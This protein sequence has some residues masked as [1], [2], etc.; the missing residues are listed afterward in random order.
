[1]VIED[2]VTGA[3]DGFG[4]ALGIPSETDTR[5]NVVVVAG[6]AFADAKSLFCGG[7]DGGGRL[8][9]RRKR[10]VIANAGVDD[11]LAIHARR[12]LRKDADGN[13]VE[14]L[15]GVADALNVAGRNAQ[16]V[17]LC[18]G[19]GGKIGAEGAEGAEVDVAAKVELEDLGFGRA[20]LDEVVVAAEFEGVLAAGDGDVVGE[21]VA[22]FDAIDGGVGFA[23][24]I[25]E[26]GNVNADA[27]AAGELGKTEV[28]A[29][30]GELEAEL[31]ESAIADDGVV[32]SSAVQIAGLVEAG[33]GAGVLG[34]DLV[35]RSGRKA[36][37]K[38]RRDA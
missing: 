26:A 13:V 9:E 20:Q 22:A 29:A 8:E 38:G 7:V 17:G 19:G 3:N 5:S 15:I 23:A 30:T 24:E 36:G 18:T 6:D 1:M 16:A 35:L 33:A 21:F 10:D 37:D 32:L 4:V 27:R 11:E 31:I 14:G 12:V 28:Q 25:G 34:K 2:A